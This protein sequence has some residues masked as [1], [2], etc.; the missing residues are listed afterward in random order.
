M[1]AV[2]YASDATGNVAGK[3][4]QTNVG[5]VV[6]FPKGRYLVSAEIPITA[7]GG[8]GR[9]RRTTPPAPPMPRVSTAWG[10]FGNRPSYVV[11]P[12]YQATN[13]GSTGAA[14][15][16]PP[17]P[18]STSPAWGAAIRAHPGVLA[19]NSPQTPPAQ[20]DCPA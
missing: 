14:A 12:G 17:P 1:A 19:P 7:W 16:T 20:T 5:G 18:T 10:G 8:F 13:M 9:Q 3:A 15:T 11:P 6:Y 4:Y 2:K